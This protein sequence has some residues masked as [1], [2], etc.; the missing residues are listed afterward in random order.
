MSDGCVGRL[1]GFVGCTV[2]YLHVCKHSCSYS[3][4]AC[5]WLLWTLFCAVGIHNP[6]KQMAF[7][8]F[9]MCTAVTAAHSC[10]TALNP[11]TVGLAVCAFGLCLQLHH[12]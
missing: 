7:V 6:T 4:V 2:M 1:D 5:V 8:A 3:T 9:G 10:T 12:C 11:S